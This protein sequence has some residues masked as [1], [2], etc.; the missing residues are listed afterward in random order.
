LVIPDLHVS[1]K[2]SAVEYE[3]SESVVYVEPSDSFGNLASKS[4]LLGEHVRV[5]SAVSHNDELED[6]PNY[7]KDFNNHIS[8]VYTAVTVVVTPVTLSVVVTSGVTNVM[9]VRDTDV[10][11][12]VSY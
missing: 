6:S 2:A 5:V 11:V 8:L 3:L 12:V 10:E 1:N 7:I 9:K 4:D